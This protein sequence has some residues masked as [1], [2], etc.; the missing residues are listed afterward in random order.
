[1][2]PYLHPRWV[3]QAASTVANTLVQRHAAEEE[4]G[5]NEDPLKFAHGL[6]GVD[7]VGN[8]RW[9]NVLG[10]CF[11]AL[12]IGTL[13]L[14]IVDRV[15][16]HARHLT[17]MGNPGNQAFWARN[18]TTW[19]PWIERHIL[20]AP[21]FRKRHNQLFQISAAIDNGTL[22]GR[23]HTI[24][25]TIYILSNV[26]YC[27]ALPWD[28]PES[29]SVVAALRG[30]SGTLSALN[31]VPTVI[32]ALRNNPLIWLLKISYDDF[33]LMHRWA[34]RIT[35][36]EAIVHTLCWLVNTA[37]GGGLAAVAK[38]LR[39][40][41]SYGWGMVAT[42][43][44]LF[45]F[46]QACSPLR[47]A[48]YETFLGIHKL[49]VMG[50]LIGTILHL[51]KHK[52]PQFPWLQ[53]V[54]ILW[55]LEYF[56]RAFRIFWFNFKPGK[57]T[58]ITIEA[59]P[60][61][62]VRITAFMTK[63]WTPR[64]GCHVHMYLPTISGLASHPFSVAWSPNQNHILNSSDS[65]S[66]KSSLSLP[67]NTSDLKKSV[68]PSAPPRSTQIS[69]ICR[70]RT[71]LTRSMYERAC[72]SPKETFHTWGMLE[73]PYGTHQSLDSYGTVV[74][75]AGGVGITHQVMYI[76]QL[77]E[78][79]QNKTTCTQKIL[80]VWQVPDS[81]CLEW[82]RPWMDEIL[83]MKSRKKVLRVMLFISRPKKPLS[84]ISESV[85]MIP[86]R[87]DFKTIVQKEFE[88]RVGAMVVQCC[89]SG[90]FADDVRAAV[91]PKIEE[92]S[93]EYIEEAF[94]Y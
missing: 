58:Q 43:L 91:R 26:A 61:E 51:Q 80:L 88:D 75:F 85:R 1:M 62:A 11:A 39:T 86:G 35:I 14:R 12:C 60:G 89:G 16:R 74:L 32:F 49:S 56:C 70:A 68:A 84:N 50:A 21:L 46:I 17:A 79:F 38:E 40:Q 9:V 63:P 55:G 20:K 72:K 13:I 90:G 47:H 45:I 8:Y 15:Y 73:G 27:L 69:L 22:P 34:A 76:K 28:R 29:A 87:C 64:P 52:L 25:L 18:Q 3:E 30:R 66:E 31:L 54:F 83:R 59:M 94:T 24:I 41:E 78:G 44:F 4:G 2:S 5:L 53:A 6:T 10:L 67:S 57:V 7:Q 81:E 19:W 82:V 37:D 65:K 23:W 92:G 36:V 71:G 93:V 42:V 33:N 77:L 48:F